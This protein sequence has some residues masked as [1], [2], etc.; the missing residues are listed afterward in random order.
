LL[1]FDLVSSP[2]D[3]SPGQT[4]REFQIGLCGPSEAGLSRNRRTTAPILRGTDVQIAINPNVIDGVKAEL[5][6]TL[7]YVKSSHRAEA[8]ARGL[9]W[10]TNAAMRAELSDGT[11]LRIA[12]PDVFT[13]YLEQHDFVV[14]GRHFVEAIRRAQIRA[15]MDAHSELTH[16]GFG[17]YDERRISQD[18]WQLRYE[19][20][21]TEM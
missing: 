13:A 21:R 5:R 3:L 2:I 7:P 10:S 12:Q 6:Q 20:R 16:H 9:G 14:E 17:V 11:A 4:L 19:T 8:I 18:E 1:L 15:V